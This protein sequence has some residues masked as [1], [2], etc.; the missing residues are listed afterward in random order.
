MARTDQRIEPLFE[1]IRSHH[2]T[3]IHAQLEVFERNQI[4]CDCEI[5]LRS[6]DGHLSRSNVL[7]LP[8]RTAFRVPPDTQPLQLAQVKPIEPFKPFETHKF[9]PMILHV[10]NF[11]WDSLTIRL[12]H[13]EPVPIGKIRNWYLEWFQPRRLGESARLKGVVHALEGPEKIDGFCQTQVNLG[14]AP[15]EALSDLLRAFAGSQIVAT[16]LGSGLS[17]VTP[18]A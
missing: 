15:T 18:S 2:I 13:I 14:T 3:R 4:A 11:N 6:E 1:R 16:H 17:P 9:A 12:E 10:N 8:M 7:N 5:V